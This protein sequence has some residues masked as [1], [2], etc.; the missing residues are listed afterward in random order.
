MTPMDGE[1]WNGITTFCVQHV[2]KLMPMLCMQRVNSFKI[3]SDL[4][5]VLLGQL[6]IQMKIIVV[7][8]GHKRVHAL[9]FQSL[10][11]PN[12]IIANT[13]GPVGGYFFN[14]YY[15]NQY[16]KSLVKTQNFSLL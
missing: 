8:I 10:A 16:L 7:Y 9:K 11:L 15:F 14:Q 2:Y 13:Y 4:W 5:T 3:V 6:H 12:G 1:S